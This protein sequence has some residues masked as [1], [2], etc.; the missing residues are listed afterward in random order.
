MFTAVFSIC[1][2]PWVLLI[3][4]RYVTCLSSTANLILHFS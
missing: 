2:A 1:S 3:H 4:N